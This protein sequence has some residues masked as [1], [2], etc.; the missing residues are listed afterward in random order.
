MPEPVDRRWRA[1]ADVVA[2][3]LGANV[4]ISMVVLP[5]FFVSA[6]H[7]PA[8][9]LAVLAAPV[10]LGI[11]VWRRSE[12]LLLGGFPSA[13][14]LPLALHPDMATSNVYGPIRFAIVAVSLVAYFFGVPF[15]T[16][17]HDPPRPVSERMLSSAQQPRPARW[18][19]RERVYWVMAVLA[20]WVPLFLIWQ[21]N[22]DPAIGRA[23]ARYYPG[24]I[25]PMTTLLTLAA[26]AL[27]VLLFAWVFL[28]VMRPHR[29]GDRDLVT[30]LALARADA[31][32]GRPR[33]RFYVGV[34]LALGFM[35]TMVLLRHL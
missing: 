17:F 20:A 5:G 7:G 29:T 32:R 22:Y 6:L 23:V 16:T 15:F 3:A 31:V 35:A 18:R 14:L 19:R 30:T 26:V 24:R 4:W 28:G 34:V 8:M 11:G 1:F 9:W 13:L 33:Y 25:E 21:V 10:A 12:L 27:S 2:I